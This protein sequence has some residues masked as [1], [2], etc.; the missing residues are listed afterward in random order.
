[1]NTYWECFQG[2]KYHQ[3]GQRQRV[4][5]QTHTLHPEKTC[6]SRHSNML[7]F[8]YIISRVKLKIV[9]LKTKA[10]STFFLLGTR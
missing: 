6:I 9:K 1:M 4:P 10:V 2:L 7:A 8:N 3:G 5:L